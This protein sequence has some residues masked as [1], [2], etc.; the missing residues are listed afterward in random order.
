MKIKPFRANA[1]FLS[2][3]KNKTGSQ[4]RTINNRRFQPAEKETM[5]KTNEK[6][7]AGI[8]M[9]SA[10]LMGVGAVLWLIEK[11]LPAYICIFA[12]SFLWILVSVIST[13]EHFKRKDKIGKRLRIGV[14]VGL[15]LLA[16]G[17]TRILIQDWS[18]SL[19]MIR[20]ISVL[21]F[22]LSI[23]TVLSFSMITHD[24]KKTAKMSYYYK[25]MK[26]NRLAEPNN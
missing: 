13:I 4:S 1:Q 20:L 10:V 21:M 23:L 25:K 7:F 26:Q 24:E 18:C 6:Y 5:N 12:G 11:F 15:S 9:F 17:V 22:W 3:K 19:E 16:I 14:A 8:F 2:F